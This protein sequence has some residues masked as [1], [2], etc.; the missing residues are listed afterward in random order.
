MHGVVIIITQKNW[1]SRLLSGLP[2]L[3]PHNFLVGSDYILLTPGETTRIWP[4]SPA[5]DSEEQRVCCSRGWVPSAPSRASVSEFYIAGLIGFSA[6]IASKVDSISPSQYFDLTG[7]FHTSLSIRLVPKTPV[8]SLEDR[9]K[10][11]LGTI[12]SSEVKK[13][14]DGKNN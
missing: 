1:R 6:C 4:C 5:R 10:R 3:F 11:N 2:V 7:V 13:D 14:K 8:R 9:L 12:G